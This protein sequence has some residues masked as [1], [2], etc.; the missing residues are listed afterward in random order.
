MRLA[1][2]TGLR[3]SELCGLRVTHVAHELEP[4]HRLDLPPQLG[5]CGRGRVIP[6][7]SHARQAVAE[8]LAFNKARGFQVAPAAP[9]L[10]TRDH[11]EL[12]PRAVRALMQRYREK[13][14]LDVRASPHTL[15]H[16]CASRILKAT[17]NAHYA[18]EILGHARLNTV[19]RYLHSHP[20]ELDAAAELA[21]DV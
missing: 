5:K 2:H 17:G 12:T 14:G 7:N 15:R 1:L 8:L 18:K 19:T 10:Y 21:G 3:V 11:G 13:A 20:S 4:R 16:T 6:L 9:L